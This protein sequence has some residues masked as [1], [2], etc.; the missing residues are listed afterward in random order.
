MCVSPKMTPQE[1]GIGQLFWSIRDAVVVAD[2]GTD[3][4]VLW[5]PAAAE[6][7]GY[8]EA[9]AL[10]L[11]LDQL[12][13]EPFKEAHRTGLARYHATGHGRLIDA[14]TPFEVPA[15]R[16]TGDEIVIELMLTPIHEALVPGRFVL[17]IIR[18]VTA[19]KRAEEQLY[20]QAFHD[21]LTGL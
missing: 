14:H 18:D 9:E 19:R 12:V 6:I 17:A 15:L 10:A 13:P 7:F 4:I 2:A 3:R 8:S 21:P 11:P 20:H 5:N 16:K 1:V